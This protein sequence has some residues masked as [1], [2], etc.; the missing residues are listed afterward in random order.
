MML[1]C[2]LFFPIQLD[3]NMALRKCVSP[4]DASSPIMKPL[5]CLEKVNE[6]A[7]LEEQESTA[8]PHMEGDVDIDLGEVYFLIMHFLSAG[9]CRR[10]CGHFLNELVEHQLLPRRYHAWYSR[11][12]LHSGHEDDNGLSFPLSYNK[13]AERYMVTSL[14]ISILAH[15]LSVD[16]ILKCLP[17]GF[18]FYY[19]YYFL[20][21]LVYSVP[22]CF[23]FVVFVCLFPFFFF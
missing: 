11:S 10:T 19:Y 4:K 12:G 20:V 21:G 7:K 15:A 5:N 18:F 16:V 17:E 8:G 9:P 2:N 3:M 22:F 13:L 1:S 6:R 23:V 14:L